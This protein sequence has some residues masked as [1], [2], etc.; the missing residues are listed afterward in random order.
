VEHIEDT[1]PENTLVVMGDRLDLQRYCIERKVR[2]LILS[3]GHTL[4]SELA[5][6]AEAN[7]VTVMSSPYDTS[8]TAMMVIYSIPVMSMGD[9]S[10]PL[11]RLSDPIRKVQGPLSQA[12]SRSL[13]IGDE[14]GHVAGV[15][16]EGDLLNEPNIEIIMVDHNEL[17]QAIEGIENYRILEVIDHHRLGN[18]STKYPIT[19][20]NK[21]V[22]AT[23]TIITNLYR[24]QRVPMKKEIASIL[25]CGILTDTLSL[26]SATATVID[27]EAAEYLAN[28]TNLDIAALS[29]E[30]LDVGNQLNDKPAADLIAM[31]MKEYIEKGV[32]FSVSQIETNN[33]DSLAARK[34][35]IFDALEKERAARERLFAALLVTDVTTLNSLLFVADGNALH[36]SLAFPRLEGNIYILKD[37][38]S[39]KKQ[40]IPLLAEIVES[41]Q[42]GGKAKR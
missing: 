41:V 32:S 14:N 21:P 20:I 6:L 40:L 19:F 18:M 13:P 15:L 12:P 37:I 17:S 22:G 11:M 29:R 3:N 31:D 10:V 42:K 23:C 24:E 4:G 26:K 5:A 39:R 30:I 28:V 1:D 9:T 33:P 25:L 2:A 34:D 27:R 38:V 8:S 36:D 7:R 35:A 16:F